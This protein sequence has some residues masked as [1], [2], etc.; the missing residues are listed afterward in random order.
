[1]FHRPLY[2]FRPLANWMND[3][4]GLMQYRGRYHMFYQHYPYA[5]H[6]GTMYWGHAVSDD[7]VHWRH[8]PI[9]LKPT[10]E[11]ADRDGCWSGCAVIDNG[12]PIL[13]YTGVHPQAQ[14]LA[15]PD[16]PNDPDLVGWHAYADN[17]VLTQPEGLG[18]LPG[19]FRDPYVWREQGEWRMV[20]GSGVQGVGG[21]VLLYRSPDLRHWELIGP[22]VQ[23][24]RAQCEPLKTGAMWECPN[25]FPLGDRWVLIVSAM[26]K[27]D[28][29]VRYTV[30]F[31][32]VYENNVFKPGPPRLLDYGGRLFYAPQTFLDEAGRRLMF[33]WLVEDRSID[34]QVAAGWA[35]VMSLP[36]VLALRADGTLSISPAPEVR[37]LRSAHRHWEDLRVTPGRSGWLERVQGDALEIQVE[38]AAGA[39]GEFGLVVRCSPD[40]QEQTLVSYNAETGQLSIDT[41]RSSLSDQVGH[42]VWRGELNLAPDEPLRLDLFLDR[43]VIEL[44]ANDRASISCRVYPTLPTSRGIDVWAT[45]A[46]TVHTVDVW[47]MG[48]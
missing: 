1:M 16:D 5:A 26:D 45:E 18:L 19:D 7:L 36:R 4:N 42:T 27:A 28:P 21:V 43:S 3:P 37:T 46:V 30:Y 32:G 31:S 25:F 9:A 24:D 11:G 12:L 34:A 8:L 23:G 29:S 44:Y 48:L 13:V 6:W 47:K 38:F 15:F 35:G 10:R 14:C 17:P 33:G 22:L 39:Y 40:G 20:L 41:R 2:H